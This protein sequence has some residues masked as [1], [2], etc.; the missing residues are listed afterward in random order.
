MLPVTLSQKNSKHWEAGPLERERESQCKHPTS[1]LLV[2]VSGLR[3]K[4]A[5]VPDA[6]IL[7]SVCRSD[8]HLGS[9]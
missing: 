1:L 2:L 3:D 5:L 6:L 9:C 7:K 8:V 4:T